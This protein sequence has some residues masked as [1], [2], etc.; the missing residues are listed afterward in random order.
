MPLRPLRLSAAVSVAALH[1][2][3]RYVAVSEPGLALHCQRVL[4][5]PSKRYDRGPVA[6]LE[7]EEIAALVAAP[8]LQN[9]DRQTR[10]CLATGRR[11]DGAPQQRDYI[12]P[13]PRRGTWGR[14]PCPLSRERAQVAVYAPS[15]RMSPRF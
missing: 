10:P 7:E 1:A 3:F 2:F 9:V 8:I 6:F 15:G 4:A 12:A 5:M 13:P 14:S 11:S